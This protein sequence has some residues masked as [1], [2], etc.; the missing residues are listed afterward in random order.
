MT[1]ERTSTRYPVVILSSINWDFLWQRHQVFA[2]HFAT[3]G[4]R[5]VFIEGL[6]FGSNYLDPSYYMRA[7][8]KLWYTVR[9]ADSK[10]VKRKLPQN[11]S[12]CLVVTA[13]LRPRIF[14]WLN[15]QIFVPRVLGEIASMGIKNPVVW[16]FQPTDTAM[17]IARGLEP[18]A[19]VYDCVVNF[20]QTPGV[21]KD[22]SETEE[23]WVDAADLVV[24]DSAFLGQKHARRRPDVVQIP[25][26]VNYGLFNQAYS[27]TD[28]GAPIRRVCFFGG[29]GAHWFDFD[30]VESI[31]GAGFKV[32][33][34]GY[35]AMQHRSLHHPNVTYTP[36]VPQAELPALLRPMDA[37]LIPYKI[38]GFT[39]GVFPTKV[40]ECLATG[41][42]VIATPLPDL[43]GELS[44]HIYLANNAEEFVNVLRRLPELE[45]QEK[46]RSRLA[47][48]RENSWE[49][50][51]GT[52]SREL[53]RVLPATGRAPGGGEPR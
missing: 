7:V 14:R 39:Q 38:N 31:A 28:P 21:P 34:I 35:K 16:S 22:I 3:A 46:V 42:P 8:R 20:V 45:T 24:V 36:S 30:L 5:V 32:S 53:E 44:N 50:R 2:T 6:S 52:V 19:L 4:H 26:G 11:L 13:P 49:S 18:K 43:Q 15:K 47:L 37:L 41:K 27:V 1:V 33:L 25:P 17:R 10:G 29:M 48:A 23:R 40:Y 9:R 12:V 51:L